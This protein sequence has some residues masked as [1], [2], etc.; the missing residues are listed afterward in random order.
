MFLKTKSIIKS[1]KLKVYA[2]KG[3]RRELNKLLAFWQDQVNHKIKI[4]WKFKEV[5]GSYPPKEYCKGGRLISDASRKAWQIVKIAKKIKQK[6]RPYFKGKEIDLN[7]FSA[8]IIPELKTKEFDIWFSV[9]SLNPRYRLKIP[10]KRTKIFNEAIKKGKLKKSFKLLKINNDYY[11]QCYVEFPEKRKENNR[12]IGIDVGLNNPIVTSDGKILG[13]ELKDLRI[14]T[15]WRSYKGRLSP[16]KQLLNY[17]AKLLVK[18]Y[19][20]TDFVVEKLS[21]KGKK[22]RSKEFRRRNHTW[23][24]MHLARKLEEIGKLE[25]FQ[26]IK[27][28]PAYSSLRCPVCGFTDKAN[29][30]SVE[31]FQCGRCGFRE[32][33]DRVGAW[34]LLGG[35]VE[36]S[37]VPISDSKKE[38]RNADGKISP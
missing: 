24:Y 32:N 33:A 25:G 10:C 6:E 30:V 1:Y 3:K 18:L 8:Y 37:C 4:F 12:K 15:K 34:N 11:M 2:N 28:N 9:I 26:L 23:A 36:E 5:K 27:L 7:Q 14:R 19:P 35:V 21:F 13:K 17:Y 31:V 22:G 38:V 20:N 16:Q 29:R